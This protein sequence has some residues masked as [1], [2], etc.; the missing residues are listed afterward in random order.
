LFYAWE[1]SK[2]WKKK[3][4][5]VACAAPISWRGGHLS[6]ISPREQASECELHLAAATRDVL[7]ILLC[8]RGADFFQASFY[9]FTTPGSH[10]NFYIKAE[11]R[12]V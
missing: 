1:K 10:A 4:V 11:A 3:A 7:N 8:Q 12:N 9:I 5:Q 6:V 2:R